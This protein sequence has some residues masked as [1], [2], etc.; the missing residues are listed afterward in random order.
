MASI[1]SSSYVLGI[2]QKDGRVPVTETLTDNIGKVHMVEYSAEPTYNFA[3]HLAE[4]AA[5]LVSLLEVQELNTALKKNAAPTFNYTVK[6]TFL[7]LFRARYEISTGSETLFLAWWLT[8]RL[9]D[10][11]ITVTDCKAAWGGVNTAVWNGINGR[12]DTY[13]AAWTTLKTAV[14]E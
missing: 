7:S 11:S 3:S 12:M 4:S 13:A 10:G 6:A 9:T 2:A 14:G 8:S 5:R 1:V